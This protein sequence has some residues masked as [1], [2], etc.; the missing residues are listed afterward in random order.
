MA[1]HDILF[2]FIIFLK[3][4]NKSL[5]E[6]DYTKISLFFRSYLSKILYI[7]FLVVKAVLFS[8]LYDERS[9]LSISLLLFLKLIK[10]ATKENFVVDQ[11]SIQ[12]DVKLIFLIHLFLF[13]TSNL[14]FL[15]FFFLLILWCGIVIYTFSKK[16]LNLNDSA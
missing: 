11:W 14:T 3:H 8:T 10:M 12:H 2:I 9:T 16:F 4:A 6:P 15:F 13:F 5:V 7:T 1:K